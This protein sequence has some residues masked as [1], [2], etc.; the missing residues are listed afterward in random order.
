MK[1]W[2]RRAWLSGKVWAHVVA[3]SRMKFTSPLFMWCLPGRIQAPGTLS[4]EEA[5]L[6]RLTS[7]HTSSFSSKFYTLSPWIKPSSS[8]PEPPW[9]C[10]YNMALCLAAHQP[11]RRCYRYYGAGLSV[12]I[13]LGLWILI[14][15]SG[16]SIENQCIF[17]GN[18]FCCCL[19]FNIT[20]IM[21]VT[22]HLISLFA[23]VDKRSES[24]LC[25]ASSKC[26]RHNGL[27]HIWGQLTLHYVQVL[28]LW[29]QPTS[30]GKY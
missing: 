17:S 23:L 28:H 8:G 24:N 25:P 20:N 9:N 2:E 3:G 7:R 29:I 16:F 10:I 15:L 14:F 26:R 30:D 4:A 22:P 21:N 1:E 6:Q 13:L 5:G 12:R 11:I 19:F 27:G 18:L